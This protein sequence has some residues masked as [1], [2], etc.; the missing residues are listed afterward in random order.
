MNGNDLV[1]KIKSNLPIG[2]ALNNPGGGTSTILDVQYNRLV[3]RR[4]NS[5]LYY[6][7]AD[8]VVAY[9]LYK[10]WLCSTINLKELEPSVYESKSNGH[11]CNCTF[12]FMLLDYFGLTEDGICGSG[13]RG[14]PFYIK[15]K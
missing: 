1:A 15:I 8:L 6:N 14:S 10:G 11:S 2:I 7:F 4:G 12:F 13:R 5:R 9:D 3:Y